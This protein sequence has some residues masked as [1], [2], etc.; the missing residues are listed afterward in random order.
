MVFAAARITHTTHLQRAAILRRTFESYFRGDGTLVTERIRMARPPRRATARTP[1]ADQPEA[2]TSARRTAAPDSPKPSTTS[3]RRL[4][5]SSP[6]LRSR[7]AGRQTLRPWPDP[8]RAHAATQ[9]LIITVATP[10]K[11]AAPAAGSRTSPKTL[12]QIIASV[13][14]FAEG[15]TLPGQRR[16]RQDPCTR[17]AGDED[18]DFPKWFHPSMPKIATGFSSHHGIPAFAFTSIKGLLVT[19]TWRCPSI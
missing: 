9:E 14:D 15:V 17:T 10:V 18:P 19:G 8:D 16:R 12:V 5:P 7:P 6:Y 11:A 13:L 1:S 3:R 2:A 4:A